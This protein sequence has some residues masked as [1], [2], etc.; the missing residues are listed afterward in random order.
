MRLQSICTGVRSC[1]G[2]IVAGPWDNITC[3]GFITAEPWDNTIPGVGADAFQTETLKTIV[4]DTRSVHTRQ[5]P[6]LKMLG[7]G[8]LMR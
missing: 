8:E 6:T 1:V 5:L 3:L 4:L 7:F 2:F